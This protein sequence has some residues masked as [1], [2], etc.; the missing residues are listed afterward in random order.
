MAWSTWAKWTG[1]IQ[2]TF[3]DAQQSAA[4]E[5]SLAEAK[6]RATKAGAPG[7]LTV[8][9]LADHQMLGR[10][11]VLSPDELHQHFGSKTP[12][13][14]AIEAGQQAFVEALEE[15]QAVAVTAWARGQPTAVLFAGQPVKR[16]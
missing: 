15:G 4:G 9:T 1:S 13:K 6:R 7:I 5:D 12:P 16:R 2:Q 3:H 14:R 11:W 10:I 8:D